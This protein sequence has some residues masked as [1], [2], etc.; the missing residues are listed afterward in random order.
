[1]VDFTKTCKM[2]KCSWLMTTGNTLFPK[3]EVSKSLMITDASKGLKGPLYLHKYHC[4][5][6]PIDKIYLK[7]VYF[8]RPTLSEIFVQAI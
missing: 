1:M 2:F 5:L 8:L 4:C 7:L 3:Y 6:L